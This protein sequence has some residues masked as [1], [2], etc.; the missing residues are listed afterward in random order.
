[1]TVRRRAGLFVVAMVF[2]TAT[3]RTT[4][5]WL[6]WNEPWHA[7]GHDLGRNDWGHDGFSNDGW[8]PTGGFTRARVVQGE[9]CAGCGSLRID[10]DLGPGRP[11]G[12]VILDLAHHL[13]TVCPAGEAGPQDLS[14][15]NVRFTLWLPRGA[16]G[17]PSA[18]SGIQVIFKTRLGDEQWASVYTAWQNID[19]GLENRWT[20]FTMPVSIVG[21]AHVDPGADLSRTRLVGIK[22][23]INSQSTIRVAGPIY[24]DDYVIEMDSPVSWDF[25]QLTIDREFTAIRDASRGDMAVARVFL[26]ADGR[27]CPE[28]GLDGHVMGFDDGAF[29]DDVDALLGAASRA[30]VRLIVT[31][32]DYG[33]AR[34]ATTVAGVQ[35]GGHADLIRIPEQ[36][37]R[38][39][40]DALAPLLRRYANHPAIL[41]WQPINEPEWVLE[42]LPERI[43]QGIDYVP[44]EAMRAFVRQ[45][46]EYVHRLSPVHDV[47]IGSARRNWT[48]FWTGLGLDGFGVHWYETLRDEPFPFR[49]CPEEL[50]R[51][52]YIEEVPT[53]GTRR[54]ASELLA[55]AQSSRYAGLA[56]WSCRARDPYSDLSA[57]LFD[58][59]GARR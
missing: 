20:T 22:V 41:A 17:P 49:R 46:A 29:Y 21:A 2:V 27:A 8:S 16:A 11:D 3:L 51:P 23:A 39:F 35:L 56:L 28:F 12:E 45:T 33:L 52:C 26:C 58:L 14:R 40:D 10:A 31:I 59:Y 18:R 4:A 34:R 1:M 19:P 53:A 24:L 57:A 55:S 9:P 6:G 15:A 30:G 36:R 42:E 13:P 5:F 50:D 32:F 25:D 43:R 47:T 44:L 7:Y 37:Q 48:P 54:R 38:F